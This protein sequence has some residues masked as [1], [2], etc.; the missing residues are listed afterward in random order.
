MTVRVITPAGD[1]F[2]DLTRGLATGA[3]SRRRTLALIG[4]SL[5]GGILGGV[6]LL[7]DA[8]AAKCRKKCK[9]KEGDAK[10]RC[11]KKCKKKANNRAKAQPK[12]DCQNLGTACG[13]GAKTLVCN[14]RLDKEGD[15]TCGNVVNPPNGMA[16]TACNLSSDCGPNEV[17]DFGGN[18]CRTK[19][20]TG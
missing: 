17:C 3:V 8:E 15:Q 20:E 5:F 18:V 1:R 11:Q 12:F 7:D 14:C 2:D 4:S 10:K 16:F 19:C 13:L 6:S 9:K